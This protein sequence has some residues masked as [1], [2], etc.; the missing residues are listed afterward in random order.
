ME[1]NNNEEPTTALYVATLQVDIEGLRKTRAEDIGDEADSEGLDE[2][3]MTEL[4]WVASSGINPY[5]LEKVEP[6]G[7]KVPHLVEVTCA[8]DGFEF[9]EKSVLLIDEGEDVGEAA[10]ALARGFEVD[11]EPELNEENRVYSFDSGKEV[12]VS[13]VKPISEVEYHILKKYL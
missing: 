5:L 11:E 4:G 6:I 10:E 9:S 8:Y 2:A 3:V 13:E 12:W 7:D 1:N